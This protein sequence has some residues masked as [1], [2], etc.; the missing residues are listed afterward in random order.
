MSLLAQSFEFV[1]LRQ[2]FT[3]LV[4]GPSM[5]GKTHL[6]T[7][8]IKSDLLQPPPDVIYWCY[9]AYQDAY[10]ALPDNVVLVDGPPDLQSLK[11]DKRRKL[12][13]LDDLML[14][15]EARD[16]NALYTVMAHH[17]N[18]SIIMMVQNSFFNQRTVRTNSTYLV[19]MKSPADQLSVATLGRQMSLGGG[20]HLFMDAYKHATQRPHGYLLVDLHQHTDDALRLRTDIFDSAPIVYVK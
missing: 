6:V 12:L 5:S 20:S 14:I 17:D 13:V 10:K 15:M 18:M 9:G 1:P 2:P 11:N 7:R 19:L 8:L 3:M 4:T 16:L